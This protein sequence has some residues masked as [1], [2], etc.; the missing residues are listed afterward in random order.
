M[1]FEIGFPQ[2]YKQKRL[3]SWYV[4]AAYW[5]EYIKSDSFHINTLNCVYTIV[6]EYTHSQP[7]VLDSLIDLG[8]GSGYFLNTIR[9]QK[10]WKRLA[11]LDFC[12]KMIQ[13]AQYINITGVPRVEFYELD[14]E[15]PITNIS[16]NLIKD[17]NI[18]TATFLLDEIENIDAFFFSVSEILQDGGRL[19]CATLDYEREKERY[20]ND[21]FFINENILMSKEICNISTGESMGELFRIFR[22]LETIN[23]SAENYGLNIEKE[24]LFSPLEMK[25]RANGPGLRIQVWQNNTKRL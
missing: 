23:T 18:A 2:N 4:L 3:D 16:N 1:R 24:I 19:I 25:S 15:Q 5:L 22:P 7:F 20:K 6:S 21:F 11:G 14:I 8:C 17:F 13:R 10:V 9:Q 12:P